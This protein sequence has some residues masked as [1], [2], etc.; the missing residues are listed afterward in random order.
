MRLLCSWMIRAHCHRAIKLSGALGVF[1]PEKEIIEV[2]SRQ[3][4]L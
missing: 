2:R 4:N 1:A 3:R